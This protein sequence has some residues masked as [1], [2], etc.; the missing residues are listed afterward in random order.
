M[1]ELRTQRWDDHRFYHQCRINQSLHF[2]SA[3]SFLVAYAMLFVDPAISGLI[4]WL[5]GMATRQSGHFFF[6]PMGFDEL[7]QVTNEH[8]EAVKTGYNM[9]RKRVLIAIWALLPLVLLL[10]PTLG[11]WVLPHT[12]FLGFVHNTGWI[13]LVLGAVGLLLRTVH[14]FFLRGVTAGLAWMTKILTDP[15]HD[16]LLYHSAPLALLRGERLERIAPTPAG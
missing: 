4:G 10:A 15:Y 12:D 8:K 2:V 16:V 5:V 7:N 9:N 13:W 6:E 1:Q 14:L 3:L 11:G